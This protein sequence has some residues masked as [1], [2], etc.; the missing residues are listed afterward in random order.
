MKSLE[1]FKKAMEKKGAVS[2]DASSRAVMAV[3]DDEA[4]ARE[5]HKAMGADTI[6]QNPFGSKPWHVIF[7]I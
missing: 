4:K 5:C 3:F 6:V 1:S 2:V 7:N